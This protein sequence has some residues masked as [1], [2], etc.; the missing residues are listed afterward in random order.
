EPVRAIARAAAQIGAE[1]LSRRL[2]VS[3]SD[4]FSDLAATMNQM[5]AR[6]DAAFEALRRAFDQQRRF[7]SDTS[8]EL[9]TPLTAI[10]AHA[11]LALARDRPPEAY[12]SA[13]RLVN[14]AA[15][16]M[17]RIVQ[18]LLLLA[19]SDAG[20]LALEWTQVPVASLL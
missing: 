18:D 5:I 19:R 7:T 20:Q 6:L 8:H 9:R 13:L 12:R 3:G 16:L 11:S 2:P 15:D 1:D 10:K 17:A 4:E 14:E